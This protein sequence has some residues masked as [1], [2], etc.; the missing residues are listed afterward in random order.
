MTTTVYLIRHAEHALIDRVLVGRNPHVTLNASGRR[1][2]RMLGR[3]LAYE[4][5]SQVQTSPQPRA[6]ETAR[7][8]AGELTLPLDF[9]PQMDE[10]DM[11]AWTGLSFEELA[12][13]PL[14]HEWNRHRGSVRPPGGESMCELQDRVVGHLA[15]LPR[16]HP[17]SEIA[18]ISHAEPIR[19]AVLHYRGLPLDQFMQV[20]IEPGSATVLRLHASGGDVVGERKAFAEASAP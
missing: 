15:E 20:R 9:V 12:R 17:D 16:L 1:H 10:L 11:G 5:I 6:I 19:A 13:D 2:A 14:W 7:R 18:I 8:I 4:A 3:S